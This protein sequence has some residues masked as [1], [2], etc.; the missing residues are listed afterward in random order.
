VAPFRSQGAHETVHKI[1]MEHS[2]NI[3]VDIN[4]NDPDPIARNCNAEPAAQVVA[5]ACAVLSAPLKVW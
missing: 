4:S 5:G 3:I 1:P 2:N